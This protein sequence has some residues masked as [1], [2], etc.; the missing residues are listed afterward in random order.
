MIIQKI[1]I[2]EF[3]QRIGLQP[4]GNIWSALVVSNLGYGELVE[5]LSETLELFTECK[6]GILSGLDGA[7]KLVNKIQ[8]ATEDYLIIWELENWDNQNWRKFDLMRSSFF[9]ERGVV[10]VISEKSVQIMFA[11]ATNIVNWL[12]ARVYAVEK[13]GEKLTNNERQ[14]KLLAL[15]EWSG[16]SNTQIIEM[17]ES[18]KLPS[19]PEYGEWLLLLG[20]ED[21]IER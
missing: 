17:A 7:S 18:H 4:N 21:L 10:L 13:S 6:V 1:S 12:G 15:S 11:S 14:T 5:E 2:D 19:D 16:F 8:E 9:R 20:R 3:L